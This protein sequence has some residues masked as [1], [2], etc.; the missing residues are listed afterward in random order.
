MEN[1]TLASAWAWVLAFC[2]AVSVVSKAWEIL[3]PGSLRRK[4]DTDAKRINRLEDTQIITLQALLALI[5]HSVD[6]KNVA[7][8]REIRAR[9]R[10]Y[11]IKR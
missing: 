3:R 7:G 2:G 9:I 8:L 6:D 4:L 11:L 1:I 10:D 5:D